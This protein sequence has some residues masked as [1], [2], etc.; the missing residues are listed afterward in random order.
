MV[1]AADRK[2]K[3]KKH[4][5]LRVKKNDTVLVLAGKDRGETGKVLMVDPDSER[6]TVEGINIC[7]RH[8]KEGQSG[9]G[10]ITDIPA[11]MHISNLV[12][13][14]PHCKSHMRPGKKTIEKRKEGRDKH[15]HV[16]MCRKCNEQLDQV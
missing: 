16:R 8:R 13:V 15:Y 1:R 2:F 5:R 11:P 14:C 12:V 7:K 3:P 4:S 6:V 9:G 10:G